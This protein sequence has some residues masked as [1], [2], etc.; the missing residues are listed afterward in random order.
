MI[1]AILVLLAVA[2]AGCSRQATKKR[3]E[4]PGSSGRFRI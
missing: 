4:N 1:L 2:A 3:P